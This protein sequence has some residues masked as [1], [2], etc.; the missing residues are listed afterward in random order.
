M[1]LWLINPCRHVY[2]RFVSFYC[3]IVFRIRTDHIRVS[4]LPVDGHLGYVPFLTVTN[5]AAATIGV[6]VL[7]RMF[8]FLSLGL[9]P[10]DRIA[11][12]CGMSR[13]N[14]VEESLFGDILHIHKDVS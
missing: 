12:S 4:H 7:V 8:D 11:G 6:Q 9:I 14:F 3:R 10:K 1:F 5:N 13:F 2:Q